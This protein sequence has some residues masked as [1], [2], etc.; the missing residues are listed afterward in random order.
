[1]MN[2]GDKD[3]NDKGNVTVKNLIF[4]PDKSGRFLLVHEVSDPN[5]RRK[6]GKP[7][8]W[9]LPG[10]GVEPNES[11]QSISLEIIKLLK[12][13]RMFRNELLLYIPKNDPFI[14]AVIR[15]TLEETGFL[16]RV[17]KEIFKEKHYG[18]NGD[19]N[20]HTVVLYKSEILSGE[21][22]KETPET[23]SAG[24][25]FVNK[26]PRVDENLNRSDAIY[27]SEERR[28]LQAVDILDLKGVLDY[29]EWIFNTN[30]TKKEEATNG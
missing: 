25:F 17:E 18:R 11:I 14:L 24:W 12:A 16:V 6:N 4:N 3:E 30:N 20:R 19:G 1:M 29:S 26:L 22:L 2:S 27:C 13:Q 10:G 15:E 21:L 5:W 7:P 28:I 9:G 8:G 23:D